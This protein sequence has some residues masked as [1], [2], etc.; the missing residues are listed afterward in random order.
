MTYKDI[1]MKREYQ[2]LWAMNKRKG[3][4]TKIKP[5]ILLS[6]EE[7]ARRKRIDSSIQNGKMRMR[8]KQLIQKYLGDKCIICDGKKRLIAHRK[9][10]LKHKKF[11]ELRIKELETELNSKNYVLVC[12]NC[13]KGVHWCMVNLNLSWEQILGHKFNR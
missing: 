11:Y 2:K 10:G 6:T 3:L 12:Y 5:R 9:D 13:H 4:S 1:R 7:K 8:K